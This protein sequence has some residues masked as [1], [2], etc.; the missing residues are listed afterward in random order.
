MSVRQPSVA[1][2]FYPGDADRLSQVVE[3]CLSGGDGPQ[4]ELPCVLVVPHAG[5][6]FSGRVAGA[7]YRAVCAPTRVI[8]LGVSH[9]ETVE[10]A[11]VD[12]S[13]YWRTPLGDMASEKPMKY[14]NCRQ[15]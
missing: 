5:Y 2:S 13:D 9:H 6:Q 7:G 8:L 11:A 4:I 3:E 14:A 12:D 10:G 1:G 15:I